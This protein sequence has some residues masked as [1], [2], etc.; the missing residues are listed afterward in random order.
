MSLIHD[1]LQY[2]KIKHMK[3]RLVPLNVDLSSKLLENNKYVWSE[4]N[5]EYFKNND[6]I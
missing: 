3:L 1:F 4:L 6:F 2:K 5:E